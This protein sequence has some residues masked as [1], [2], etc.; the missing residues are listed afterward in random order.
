MFHGHIPN[1][2][3]SLKK[4]YH[5]NI[6]ENWISGAMPPHL[7]NLTSLTRTFTLDPYAVP[8]GFQNTVGDL[9]I[10][11][12]RQKLNYHGAVILELLSIDLSSNYLRGKIREE[13]T[14]LGGLINLNLSRKGLFA[15]LKSHD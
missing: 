7:S 5:L 4:L 10:D 15:W 3:T 14:S 9:S 8:A 13:I 11:I 12:K 6:A 2:I 1:N